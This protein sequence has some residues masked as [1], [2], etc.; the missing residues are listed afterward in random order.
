MGA[1]VVYYAID[2]E[3]YA[4]DAFIVEHLARKCPSTFKV[5]ENHA[6]EL[7]AIWFSVLGV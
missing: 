2:S 1:D 5:P 7:E 3:S 4:L 6:K